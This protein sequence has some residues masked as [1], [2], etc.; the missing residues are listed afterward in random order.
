MP[1]PSEVEIKHGVLTWNKVA[2]DRADIPRYV[3]IVT[4]RNPRPRI[5]LYFTRSDYAEAQQLAT[6]IHMAGG[7]SEGGCLY[8]ETGQPL[9]KR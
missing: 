4:G 7:C 6:Q 5:Y 3:Q 2:I 1:P 9:E 8:R